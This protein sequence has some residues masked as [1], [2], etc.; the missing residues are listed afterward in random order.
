[1]RKGIKHIITAAAAAIAACFLPAACANQEKELTIAD[2]EAAID[3]YINQNFKDYPIVRRNGSNRITV[4]TTIIYSNED[5]LVFGD[6]LYFYY[7]GY[8]FNNSP[9]SLFSTNNEAVAEQ[10]GF[11]TTDPDYS[12]KKIPFTD[13]CMISGLVN[14]LYGV[15]EGGHYIIVFSAKYGFYDTYVYTIPKMSALAY[16]IWV[17]KVIKKDKQ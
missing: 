11:V 5:S 2:Q 1:M 13:G 15:R 7:A 8:T 16:E 6:S 4:D 12:V 10:N 3:S 14:G 9:T 17:D